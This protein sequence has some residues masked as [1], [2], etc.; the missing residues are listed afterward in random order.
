MRVRALQVGEGKY[1]GYHNLCLRKPGDVFDI[2][3]Q[4]INDKTGMPLAFSSKWMEP[5]DKATNLAFK[6]KKGE[7]FEGTNPGE[8][9]DE[10]RAEL[11]PLS[12]GRELHDKMT[13][14]GDVIPRKRGNP[15][16]GRKSVQT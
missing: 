14:S 15:N 4:P 11:V 9:S 5:V 1:S 2:D 12:Q 13:P 16:F 10:E 8:P 3:D 6:G 7:V